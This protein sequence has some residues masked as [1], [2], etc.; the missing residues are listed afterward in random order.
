M[1]INLSNII[2]TTNTTIILILFLT[3]FFSQK[4]INSFTH[5][6]NDSSF[7]TF[8][9]TTFSLINNNN[10]FFISILKNLAILSLLP[11]L[12]N[13]LIES[14][15]T[16]IIL[17]N[18][19]TN[20][21]FSFTLEF[22]FDLNFNIFLSIALFVSWSIIEFSLYYMNSDPNPNNFFRLL[23]IFLLNMIILTSSNNIFLLF[24]GWEGVGFLSFLLISWWTTR[25]NTNNSALQAIIYNRIGD[26]GILLFFSLTVTSF[27]SWSL[28]E[29]SISLTNNSYAF[30]LLLMG[31]LLAATGKSAQFGLH[32][33]L[34]AAMEG[35]TPVSAL[36]HS[37]T[38]VVAGIFLLIRISPLYQNTP[39]FN[40]WCLILGSITA[41]FA[42]TT[43][44]SQHDIK[45][46][47]AYS[48]TSQLGLMMISIGLNQPNIALF[49]I[50]THAFF[51]AMLFL[52]SGSI[53]HSLNNEQDIRKMGGLQLILPNTAAC[54]LL[55]S[56]A[57]SGIPFLAGFY[58]KDLILELGLTNL[59]NLFGIILSFL[60]TLLTSV[61]SLRIIFFCFIKNP[62]FLPMS[63]TNEENP[64]LTNS[65]NRLALGT[66]ISGW[67]I[68]TFILFNQP[69]TIII[70]LKN[71]AFTITLL[72]IL[73][74]ISFLYELSTQFLPLTT[75]TLNTFTTNQWFYENLLHISTLLTTFFSS[76]FLSTR[77]LDRGWSENLGAQGIGHLSIN[78]SQ[79]YQLTQTGYIKQYL[80]FSFTTFS[81]MLIVTLLLTY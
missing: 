76:L 5:Q 73:F 72:S 53:I 69:P 22:H 16:T 51:K 2:T 48:T 39:Y 25:T 31:A 8:H 13:I 17:T 35:P 11:L 50:C 62:S 7:G 42:A 80:V 9:N 58:S 49:H 67:L 36:L 14:P 55:G 23:I 65:L 75:N 6:K 24:I 18:W 20:N 56:L 21:T 46:I 71:L 33:W 59:S 15:D 27:N 66:I 68:S 12:S 30:N 19:L 4:N 1:L 47:I 61:Y 70:F 40:T 60:A 63:P 44:I 34:P 38:M 52:S 74:S 64:N 29:I 32:P 10:T 77:N 37:S 28:S 3:T 79:T 81:S 43:A 41:T 26:I 78:T 57:L 45:K 54:I